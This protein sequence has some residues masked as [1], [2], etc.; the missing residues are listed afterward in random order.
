LEQA[1]FGQKISELLD[2]NRSIL[3]KEEKNTENCDN[4]TLLVTLFLLKANF[5]YFRANLIKQFFRKCGQ[6][7]ANWCF[8]IIVANTLSIR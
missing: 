8:F 6:T 7:S 2:I 4:G 3:K 5:Y 1:H